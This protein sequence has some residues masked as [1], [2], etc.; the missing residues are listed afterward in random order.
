[1]NK[2]VHRRKGRHRTM[3]LSTRARYTLRFLIQVARE[4][5]DGKA[6]SLKSVADKTRISRRYLEQ[7]AIGLKN[8]SLIRGVS[9]RK[10]GYVL[11]RH[12]E[13]ITIGQIFEAAIGP[14]NIVE[15]VKQ[16]ETCLSADVC[17]CRWMYE[18]INNRINEVLDE[19][20]LA[21]LA[22]RK[23]MELDCK[24]VALVAPG[25]PAN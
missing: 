8:A 9:G 19:F 15:C 10:G 5:K 25:C 16:P 21:D 24:T 12:P 17:E 2:A 7:L 23:G 3:K 18:L 20:S 22:T 4:S 13:S 14:I 6:V 1:V 11:A